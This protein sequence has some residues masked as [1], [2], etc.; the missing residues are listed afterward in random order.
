MMW[1]TCLLVAV[2]MCGTQTAFG[3]GLS[4]FGSRPASTRL[5][6]EVKPPQPDLRLSSFHAVAGTPFLMAKITNYG[7]RDEPFSKSVSSGSWKGS[8]GAGANYVFFD[9][10]SD[11]ATTLLPNND[12]LIVSMDSLTDEMGLNFSNHSPIRK[13]EQTSAVQTADVNRSSSATVRWHMVELVKADT[14]NDGELTSKDRRSLGIA[15]A[16]GFGFAEVIPN[17][18]EVF[19]QTM[20]DRETLLVI[21]GSQARQV[22]VRIDLA[23]RKVLSSKPLPNFGTSDSTRSR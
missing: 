19:S 20:V 13:V 9:T 21:H 17:L 12:A 2:V 16:N 22:A 15:D 1:R 6:P 3:Q 7:Q 11:T 4:K 10:T 18:G 5:N 8:T 14:D 23:S